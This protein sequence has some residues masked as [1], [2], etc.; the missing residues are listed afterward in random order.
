[1]AYNQIKSNHL[2][3]CLHITND[4]DLLASAMLKHPELET[5]IVLLAGTG[6]IAISYKIESGVPV[7]TSRSGG[8]GWILGDGGSGFDLGRQGVQATLFALEATRIFKASSNPTTKGLLNPFHLDIMRSLGVPKKWI[9][10]DLLS[11]ILKGNSDSFDDL[12]SKIAGVALTV[13]NAAS[14]DSEAIQIVNSGGEALVST[15]SPRVRNAC[16]TPEKS[17]LILAGGLMK[18]QMY[19]D[20]VLWK[21]GREGVHFPVVEIIEDASVFGVESLKTLA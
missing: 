2:T 11:H 13:L 18:S 21:M 12:K 19:R 5:G 9:S 20:I 6:S 10:F 14:S 1:M 17:V 8:W 15:L 4:I 3:H 16:V 7:R